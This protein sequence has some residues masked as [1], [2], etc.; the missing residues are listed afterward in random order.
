MD[1]IKRIL[2]LSRAEK[3][4][5]HDKKFH[6]EDD[7]AGSIP[8]EI[9]IEVDLGFLGATEAVCQYPP[10]SQETQGG[11]FDARAKKPRIEP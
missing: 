11:N 6:D 3:G 8:D 5:L 2:V 4:K 9:P 7:I 1:E 10:A